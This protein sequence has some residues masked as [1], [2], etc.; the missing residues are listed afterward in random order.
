MV[1]IM[2]LDK[3]L[4]L[5]AIALFFSIQAQSQDLNIL[6]NKKGKVGFAD[7]NGIEVIKCEYESAM[8]FSNGTAIV[9]KSGKSGII[10]EKGQILLPL[11]YS[12]ITSWTKDLYLIKAG[13][14]MG[15]ADHSGKVLLETIYSHISKPNCY[16]RALIALGG[17]ATAND[18]KTYMANAKYGI[19][20]LDG[21]ILVTPKYK[22]LYEFSFNGNDKFPYYEG[23]R[24]EYSY[25]NTV[26]T[27][28]T[29]CSYLG[30]SKNGYYIYGAGII[31]ES[32]NELVKQN[33][34]DFVMY[35][36]DGMVRYYIIKKKQTICGYHNLETNE[37]IKVATFDTALNDM[38]FWSHGD[39]IGNIAPVNGE[40]WSFIDKSGN[41]LRSGF[42]SLKCS[43]YIKLWAA[44]NS[45]QTWDVF[46]DKNNDISVLSNYEEFNFPKNEE[47]EE[48]FSVKKNDKYGCINRLGEAI[49]PFEYEHIL[50]NSYNMMGVKK[51]GKW[52]LISANNDTIIATEYI[53]VILP[54]EYNTKHFWAQ[55]SDS[56]FYHINL[57]T[58][59]QSNSGYKAVTNFVN[60]FAHVEPVT[61]LVDDT[62]VNR[63]QMYPPHTPKAIIDSLDISKCV[64]SFGYILSTEDILLFDFPVSTE[65]KERVLKEMEKLGNRALTRTEKKKILLDVTKENRS[66][67]LNSTLNEDEWNY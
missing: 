21:R 38:N 64:D 3:V 46:D 62:P 22:G 27:L 30:F 36:Q 65:Y 34:Y 60:G 41:V 63:A 44:K 66:Y 54:S 2:R 1:I 49:V 7:K 28:I 53:N 18:K 6:V 16:G 45:S 33:L 17:T 57:D 4:C 31:D 10:N 15:L 5:I 11:K 42:N 8:P 59:T 48:V 19:I 56:L 12:S 29:D 55:K 20:D 25:H 50:S 51:N 37:N 23:K 13:K 9:T 52:G 58:K 14:K 39:F 67:D 43:R 32:G 61:M 47:D 35:P 24:L 26:D 40:T